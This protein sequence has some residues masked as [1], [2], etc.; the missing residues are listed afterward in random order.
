VAPDG[1][2]EY[3]LYQTL[4]GSWPFDVM[5]DDPAARDGYIARIE[6]Y[7]EKALH[8]AKVNLS[9]INPDPEYTGTVRRFVRGIL[10]PSPRGR[11]TFF[12]KD[13]RDFLPTVQFFGALNSLSQCLLKTTAP[14]VPDLYQGN[15]LFDFS[16]VDPDNRRPVD[17]DIRQKVIA[18][19]H[20]HS[21]AEYVPLCNDL[22]THYQD[23]R[24]KAWVTMRALGH[25]RENLK[26]FREGTYTP[27]HAAGEREHHVCSFARGLEGQFSLTAVPRFSYTLMKGR[28]APP[29]GDAWGNTEL[30]LPADAPEWMENV[31]TGELL[32]TTPQRTLLARDLF[33]NFPLA[34]LAGR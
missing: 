11:L 34:L 17:F 1:N 13:V 2:E 30:L 31:L 19:L 27:L 10:T 33:A 3:F 28:L 16:L 26:L 14:G 12:L 24:I 29:L 18:T 15:E 22:L 8:E 4:V 7:M 9:W 32:R 21:P 23:S 6:S 5:L 20:A 25:R